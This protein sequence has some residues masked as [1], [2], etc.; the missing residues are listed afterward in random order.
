MNADSDA[1]RIGAQHER[2]PGAEYYRPDIDGLRGIAVLA[3]IG[4]HASPDYFPGGFVGVDVFFVISGFLISSIILRQLRRSRFTLADF[5]ARRIRRIFPALVIVLP[6]CLLFG[7]FALLPHELE[8]LGKHVASAAAYV[9]NFTL[10]QESG[11]FDRA[12]ELKPLLHLWSLG[13]EEQFYLVWPV[14]LLL[15]WKRRQNLAVS[16]VLL[17]TASFALSIA[18]GQEKQIANFYFPFSRFWE[19]GLGCLLAVVKESP[20]SMT[21]WLEEQLRWLSKDRWLNTDPAPS[22]RYLSLPSWA[23]SVL[24]IVGVALIG[25]AIFLLDRRTTFPG[26]ATLLPTVGAMCV[27]WARGDSWFQRRIV[28]SAGLVLIGVISYPLYLWHWPLLSF[29]TILESGTPESS[30]RIAAVLLSGV[31]AWLTFKLFEHPIRT[32]RST[33]AVYALAGALAVFGATGLAIYAASGF[34]GRFDLNVRAIQ[35]G[36]RTNALCLDSFPKGRNFN[37]CKSTS[38]APPAAVFLGDSRAQGVYDGIAALMGSGYPLTLLG[39]GGCPPLLNAPFKD[40]SE[41][42]ERDCNEVWGSFVKYVGDV[43]PPVVVVVGGGSFLVRRSAA[44]L[45]MQ[46][47][48]HQTREDAF[49]HG[50]R[51]LI[52]AL[53]K[54]SRVIYVREIPRFASAPSCF[55]RRVRL[56]RSQ[57]SPT[58]DRGVVEEYLAS[59]NRVVDDIEREFPE[60]RVVDSIPTVCD[61]STCSQKLQSGEILYSDELHLSPAGGRYFARTSGLMTALIDQMNDRSSG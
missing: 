32:R 8:H 3:V 60:L 15:L 54:T 50:L 37:Y 36:P 16:I 24:P 21:Q 47:I 23:H 9:S 46:G 26:W 42:N 28:A 43:K 25:A 34:T 35:P 52:A 1:V 40:T 38:S 59:Y 4:F 11:Y 48:P 17:T 22:R 7:W 33:R 57:C 41:T 27:I 56:P 31:L 2:A 29:A 19:L 49:R 61:A 18:V 20:G 13:I 14:L 39:R 44:A 12:A 45:E 58:V 5:Y 10:W 51:E 6:A 55:L 30:V 53:Q